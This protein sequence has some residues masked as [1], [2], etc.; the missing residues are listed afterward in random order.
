MSLPSPADAAAPGTPVEA[1]SLLTPAARA[2]LDDP[3]AA[4]GECGQVPVGRQF[5]AV[6][7][8][9]PDRA[10]IT[11]RG[12]SASYGELSR[13]SAA[14]AASLPADAPVG[15]TIAVSGPRSFG[16]VA[17]ALAVLRTRCVLLLV[18]PA[19]PAQRRRT[20]LR[21]ARARQ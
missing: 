1:L 6:A 13:W 11:Q 10:A 19:L 5:E 20:I 3:T 2:T 9:A 4:L 12:Q 8:A 7:A 17:A 15:A 16:L 21:E 18:D 14:I